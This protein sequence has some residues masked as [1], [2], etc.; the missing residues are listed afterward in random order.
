MYFDP[1]GYMSLCKKGK[2]NPA[3]EI[4]LEYVEGMDKKQFYRKANELKILGEQGFL[5]KAENP[6]QR[7]P[8]VT[9]NYRQGM[10]DRIWNQYHTVN[11]EFADALINRVTTRMQP[12]HIWEL[13]LG[14]PD[15][16]S[17]LRFLDSFTNWHV[18][19]I[20]IRSQIRNLPTGTPITIKIKDI[21]Q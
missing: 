9:R 19:S 3:T 16:P 20:Q 6:V 14:G 4:T 21:S 2:L 8:T 18:G 10:I 1:S 15:I 12:D 7:D 17:N 13:Q 5:Y 11:P